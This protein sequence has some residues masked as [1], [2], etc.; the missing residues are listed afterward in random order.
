M[1]AKKPDGRKKNTGMPKVRQED[2]PE[3]IRL[4]ETGMGW[5]EIGRGYGVS[6]TTVSRRARAW[7]RGSI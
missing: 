6:G 1:V 2:L 3:I 4:S 7:L 5:G